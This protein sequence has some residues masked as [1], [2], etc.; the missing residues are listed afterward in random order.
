MRDRRKQE[1]KSVFSGAKQ[2]YIRKKALPLPRFLR[3]D[4]IMSNLLIK[5]NLS[6]NN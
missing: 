4:N 3:D 5:T 1:M 6:I 2:L